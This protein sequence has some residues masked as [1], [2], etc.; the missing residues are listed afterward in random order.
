M[1]EGWDY[2]KETRRERSGV[3]CPFCEEEMDSIRLCGIN[4]TVEE[5]NK[6]AEKY[7]D[8]NVRYECE[9]CGLKLEDEQLD[10]LRE[11][12]GG[13]RRKRRRYLCVSRDTSDKGVEEE[14]R[15]WRNADEVIVR[16]D[17]DFREVLVDYES[18]IND[19]EFVDM[20]ESDYDGRLYDAIEDC[21]GEV[22]EE[23]SL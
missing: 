12:L 9:N 14:L 3:S 8:D 7:G 4:L 23:V 11:L 21:F 19:S 17:G 6:F 15:V 5:Q 16:K 10:T 18:V 2:K 22:I 1:L 13:V 20:V